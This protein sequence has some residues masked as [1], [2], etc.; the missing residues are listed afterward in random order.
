IAFHAEDALADDENLLFRRAVAQ[1]PLEVIHIVVAETDRTRRRPQRAL[2]QRSVKV[3][4][5]Y[6]HVALLGESAQRGVV[7]LEASAENDRRLLPDECRQLGFQLYVDIQRS[8]QEPRPA[9]SAA[10]L[11]QGI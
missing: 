5:A 3:V 1:A 7:G 8:V 2:H 6:Q 9:A 11:L 4:V 10:V